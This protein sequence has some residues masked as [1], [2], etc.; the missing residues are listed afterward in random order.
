MAP[1]TSGDRPAWA[2]ARSAGT[3]RPS[4][5]TEPTPISTAAMCA[6]GAKS[7][8]APTD[9]WQG[10]T[11]V[12]P[13]AS[14]ASSNWTVSRRTPDAPWARLASL[15]AIMSRAIDAGMG[16]PTPAACDSTMLR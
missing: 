15:R 16:W 7:P 3:G 11:G 5:K 10:T 4:T 1:S 2:S 14:K 9:P 6:S 13:R 8:E 12:N